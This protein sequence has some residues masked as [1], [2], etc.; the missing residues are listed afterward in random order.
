MVPWPLVAAVVVVP[1]VAGNVPN[2]PPNKSL[3]A[4]GFEPCGCSISPKKFVPGAPTKE[5]KDQSYSDG[6]GHPPQTQ[7]I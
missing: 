7:N 6:T 1:F 3:D 5:E 4:D 2:P